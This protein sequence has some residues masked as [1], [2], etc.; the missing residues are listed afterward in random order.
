MV[1]AVA[2]LHDAIGVDG[3]IAA[4][5]G[6]VEADASAGE[7]VNGEA[8]GKQV[9]GYERQGRSNAPVYIEGRS[10]PG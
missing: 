7:F 3:V 1:L 5:G 2:Q 9:L 8:G 4:R 6:R 10:Y